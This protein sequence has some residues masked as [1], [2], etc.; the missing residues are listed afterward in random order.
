DLGAFPGALGTSARGVNSSAQ[1][2]GTAVFPVKSYHPFKPGKHVGF[3]Y[4]NH[5][6]VDLNTLIPTNSGFT[7]TDALGTNDPGQILCN[8]KNSSGVQRVVMLTPK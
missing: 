6:L 7:I 4:N 3:I 1:V 5:T 8:A 2:V